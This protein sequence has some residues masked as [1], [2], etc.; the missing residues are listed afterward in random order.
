MI[1]DEMRDLYDQYLEDHINNVSLAFDWLYKNLPEVFDGYDAD[2]IGSVLSKH[3]ESKYEDEEYF[4]YCEYFFGEN[5]PEVKEEFDVAW[6]HHQH[7]NPHHWQHWLLRKDTGTLK[8]LPMPYEYIIEMICDWWS[9][10]WKSNNL[11]EIFD[12]YKDN[13]PKMQLH[14]TTQDTVESILEKIKK[15][16]EELDVNKE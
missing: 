10:S 7:K 4:T 11:F 15:K 14:Q 8:S 6:L 1:N 13:L 2:Y 12:W 5:T 16:L 3:D 9:F